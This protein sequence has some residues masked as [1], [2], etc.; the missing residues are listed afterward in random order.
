MGH[1]PSQW[2]SS[3]CNAVLLAHDLP[4]PSV[5]NFAVCR[6]LRCHLDFTHDRWSGVAHSAKD[7]IG[8]MC[9]KNPAKRCAA[10]QALTHPWFH[11]VAR[12]LSSLPREQHQPLASI[13]KQ[14][15]QVVCEDQGSG[16]TTDPERISRENEAS[17]AEGLS[18]RLKVMRFPLAEHVAHTE[19]AVGESIEVT[20]TKAGGSPEGG[21]F[22][23]TVN[24][25]CSAAPAMTAEGEEVSSAQ[26]QTN[27]GLSSKIPEGRGNGSEFRKEG[28]P[29]E[30]EKR[31]SPWEA[32]SSNADAAASPPRP[33]AG[34]PTP[35]PLLLLRR[36]S[37]VRRDF[38]EDSAEADE[39]AAAA[40]ARGR[41]S[42]VTSSTQRMRG[43]CDVGLK[44]SKGSEEDSSGNVG[45]SRLEVCGQREAK[46]R[47]KS[48]SNS[49]SSPSQEFESLPHASPPKP[50][51]AMCLTAAV[52]DSRRSKRRAVRCLDTAALVGGEGRDLGEDLP[53]GDGGASPADESLP[54]A[55]ALG[56]SG[57]V[58]ETE[59]TLGAVQVSAQPSLTSKLQDQTLNPARIHARG[60]VSP[61]DSVAPP[62]NGHRSASS[63]SRERT[64]LARRLH[65]Q[66]YSENCGI[67]AAP[68]TPDTQQGSTL[69]PPRLLHSVC[70]AAESGSSR[71]GISLS[72]AV[73]FRFSQCSEF[74]KH[75]S[76]TEGRTRDVS[77]LSRLIKSAE[78]AERSR[79]AEAEG[80]QSLAN[81]TTTISSGRREP[82]HWVAAEKTKV[83][84]TLLGQESCDAVSYSERRQ[85]E[86]KC[87]DHGCTSVQVLDPENHTPSSSGR[88]GRS[89]NLSR[90]PTPLQTLQNRLSEIISLPGLCRVA[91][92]FGAREWLKAKGKGA[93]GSAEASDESKNAAEETKRP[94]QLKRQFNKPSSHSE[95]GLGK[96]QQ[97]PR[98]VDKREDDVLSS[99]ANSVTGVSKHIQEV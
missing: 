82:R 25:V 48:A 13:D 19:R 18:N 40:P 52:K 4:I 5:L 87:E 64:Q 12:P 31:S 67:P 16:V 75:S 96:R 92:A 2:T 26:A 55:A 36:A 28:P 38:T 30:Q 29:F 44:G 6:P 21:C 1:R 69:K 50:L 3:N 68:A 33:L 9:S 65:S 95:K 37:R 91:T 15:Q 97:N 86:S 60:G 81:S 42:E 53:A 90:G 74:T 46:S 58:E 70:S 56:A 10:P 32:L 88:R 77:P 45:S 72:K 98:S 14:L 17:S 22:R 61:V 8:W 57:C 47:R 99:E 35:P 79:G 34:P 93:I 43:P 49:A 7:L 11:R 84:S 41:G 89:D 39:D 54:P 66:V 62:D 59:R 27:G 85:G 20:G 76:K 94:S 24:Q 83:K 73:P 80:D 63:S 71:R 23:R 51:A 78:P